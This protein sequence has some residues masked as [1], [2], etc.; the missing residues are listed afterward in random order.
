MRVVV[1]GAG[2]AGLMA[3][4]R[5]AQ[6]GHEVV[7]LEARDRAGGR[8]WSQELIPGDPRTVIERGAE[9]VL[10][11][12]D[13][14]RTV[15]GELGL[16]LADSGMSYYQRDYRGG[17][18]AGGPAAGGPA[19]G[20]RV[21]DQD[22]ARCAAAVAAASAG[23]A[24]GTSLAGVV[25]GWEDSAALAAYLSRVEVT[26]GVGARVL[27][28]AAITDVTA[29]FERRPS[30]R[31]AGGNQR[32][33]HE[34]AARLGT[35][36][37]LNSPVRSV[38][39][40]HRGV[41]VLTDEGEAVGD[42]VIV[43]VPMAVLRRLSFSPPVPDARRDA[44]QRAGLA[45]NAKLHVPLTRAAPPSAV[46]SVPGKF[47]TWTAAD[48]TGQVQPVLHAFGGT[49]EGLAALAV[50]DGPATWASQAGALRPELAMDTGRA[51]LSTWNE[52]PWAGESYSALTVGVAGGDEELLAAP[53]GRAHFAGEHTAGAWAGLMEGAL[54]SGERAAR[55]LLAGP[56]PAG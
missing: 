10:D 49:E 34:L 3:A 19:A 11:G 8:V 2:F 13:V 4:Y 29:G 44:W 31:V 50:A 35:S 37:R 32:V 26:N 17:P 33:A 25:A 46:Q 27:A 22:V 38:E 14:M 28:A 15:L 1:A 23:A 54:R 40:D 21:T 52:D 43:A 48:A 20:D 45:W 39:H 56:P 55:E 16:S 7:V 30:W 51:L 53:A 41:R 47:W 24:P 6:A 36:V 12:Y 9:F 18:A 42:A 5:V